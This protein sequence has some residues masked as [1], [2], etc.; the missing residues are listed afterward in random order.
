MVVV[1]STCIQ[2]Y[3]SHEKSKEISKPSLQNPGY[4]AELC[5]CNPSKVTRELFCVTGSGYENERK[6]GKTR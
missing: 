2:R 6:Q 3:H 5:K 1:W 4:V